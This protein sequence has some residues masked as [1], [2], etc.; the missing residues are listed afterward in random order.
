MAELRRVNSSSRLAS[1]SMFSSSWKVKQYQQQ[2]STNSMH[3][4]YKNPI[5]IIWFVQHFPHLKYTET[6]FNKINEQEYLPIS[7]YFFHFLE[8]K[9]T[10]FELQVESPVS[11]LILQEN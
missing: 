11:Y 9:L 5:P 8:F 4:K 10:Q 2:M 3:G 7:K 1:S 6:Q